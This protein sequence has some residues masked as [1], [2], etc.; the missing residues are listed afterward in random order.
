MTEKTHPPKSTDALTARDRIPFKL[1]I[2]AIKLMDSRKQSA[3]A[4]IIRHGS[5]A[6]NRAHYDA[7]TADRT[8]L[9]LRTRS[10]TETPAP[11]PGADTTEKENR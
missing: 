8:R 11:A 5:R 2:L 1:A 9:G 4:E 3:M 7:R 6:V 10:A